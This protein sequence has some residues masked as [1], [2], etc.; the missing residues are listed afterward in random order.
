MPAIVHNDQIREMSRWSHLGS[1]LLPEPNTPV[2]ARPLVNLSFAVNY[3]IGGL[4]V[5]GYHVGNIAVHVLCGIVLF[6]LVRRTLALPGLPAVLG[7]HATDLSF[8]T[9]LVWTLHPLNTEVVAH[10][11][12]RTESMMALCYLLTLYAS[13]RATGRWPFV[14]V[15]SCLLGMACKESMVTAPIMVALFDR[16]FVFD[17][18]RQAWRQRWRLY[19]WLAA[20]WLLLA[21]LSIGPHSRLSEALMGVSPWTY[22][23]NQAPILTR[24]LRLTVWPQSSVLLYRLAARGHAPGCPPFG[25]VYRRPCRTH[26][27]G[28]PLSAQAGIPR[29]LVLDHARADIDVRADGDRSRRRAANVLA[30]GGAHRPVRGRRRADLGRARREDPGA[31]PDSLPS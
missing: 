5:T 12:Q 7:Q 19:A 1:I 16:M 24:Y 8:A 21:L 23:L 4:S 11:T 31:D 28:L 6:A 13:V 17:S 27:R 20:T 15:V 25:P 22:L 10:V 18:F 30:A 9:A 14:A 2:S 26:H 3:S 29:R